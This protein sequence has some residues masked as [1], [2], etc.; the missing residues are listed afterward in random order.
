ML[1]VAPSELQ[2]GTLAVN[3]TPAYCRFRV[4]NADTH[5]SLSVKL[6]AATYSSCVRFQLCDD[7]LL[8]DDDDADGGVMYGSWQCSDT[9]GPTPKFYN[10][11]YDSI[12]LIELLEL[13]PNEAREIIAIFSP[14]PEVFPNVVERTAP[15]L[16]SGTIQLTST[17]L[18]R[19]T[20]ARSLTWSDDVGCVTSSCAPSPLLCAG[21]KGCSLLFSSQPTPLSRTADG[22][23]KSKTVTSANRGFLH[24]AVRSE[25][26]TLPFSATVFLSAFTVSVSELQATMA[27]SRTHLMGFKITNISPLP[28]QLVIRMQ[29]MPHKNVELTVCEEDQFEVSLIGRVLV[30]DGHAS[31]NFTVIVRTAAVSELAGSG[32]IMKRFCHRTVLQCDNLRDARNSELIS[33]NVNV[34]P[35]HLQKPLVSVADPYLD[36]GAVYRGTRVVREVSICNVSRED[37]TVRLLNPRPPHCEG[38]LTLVRGARSEASGGKDIK[39]VKNSTPV[40][41]TDKKKS[42]TAVV[43]PYD[44]IVPADELVMAAQKGSL[45]VGVMYVA[46]TDS[47]YKGTANLKFELDFVITGYESGA[48]SSRREQRVVVRCVATLFTSTIVAPLTNINFGDCPV[49]Q[50]RRVT[51][52]IENPS[53]LPT[54]I[55]V[56]LRSKIVSIEGVPARLSETGAPETVGEFSIAPQSSLPLTLRMTPQRVNPT[57]CKQLTVVNVSNPAEDRLILTIEANNMQPADMELHNEFYTCESRPLCYEDGVNKTRDGASGGSSIEADERSGG[58]AAPLRAIASVPLFVAYRLLSRVNYPLELQL[59]TTGAEIGTF[60]LEGMPS[61]DWEALAVELHSCCC[62]GGEDTA[63]KLAPERAEE[64]RDGVMRALNNHAMSVSSVVLEPRGSTTL[65]ACILRNS[66]GGVDAVTKEDGINIG[67]E[68]VELRRFMRLSYRVCSTRFELGGQRAKHFG[69]VNVGERRST[70]VPIT[71]QCNSLLLL[72]VTK[73]RSVMAGYIR[74]DGSDRN[75]IYFRIRPFATKELEL[76]FSPGLKGSLEERIQFVNILNPGNEVVITVKATVTKAETFD[77]SPDS[78]SFGLVSVPMLQPVTSGVATNVRGS[79]LVAGKGNGGAGNDDSSRQVARVGARFTVSNTSSAR[80]ALRLKLDTTV[81]NSSVGGGNE[82][83]H[84]PLERFF[85]FEGID[86]RLQ[87]EMERG[88]ASSGS[89]RKL[90]E[91]IEKLEQKLKIYRRKNK[92]DKVAAAVR[93][94]E[95]LKRALMG[96]VVDINTLEPDDGD[97]KSK[98]PQQQRLQDLKSPRETPEGE[99][100]KFAA[101]KVRLQ[102]HGELLSMLLRDG[103]ALSEMNAGESIILVLGITC[104]RTAEHIP[105][106]QSG[107]L[108]FVLYE[109]NDTEAS[110]TIPVDIT[111]V[112]V[113][114]EADIGTVVGGERPLAHAGKAGGGS[115]TDANLPGILPPTPRSPSRPGSDNPSP[116]QAPPE[117]SGGAAQLTRPGP[118]SQRDSTSFISLELGD[119]VGVSSF[120]CFPMISLNNCVVQERCDF[121]FYVRTTMDTSIVVLEPFRCCGPGV[122]TSGS[123]GGCMDAMVDACGAMD[124]REICKGSA[125]VSHMATARVVGEEMSALSGPCS[126][127]RATVRT[128]DASFRFSRRRGALHSRQ[129]LSINVQCTPSSSGPQRYFIPV[130]NLQDEGNV[131]YLVVSLNPS[132]VDDGCLLK[133]APSTLSM[134]DIVLPCDTALLDVQSFAVRSHVGRPHALLIRST[135]PALV[136]LFE[137]AKCS[138]PLKNPVRCSFSEK[139]KVYVQLRPSEHSRKHASR[140]VTAGILIEAIVSTRG[141]DCGHS[142]DP[143]HGGQCG[144]AILAHS[145]VRVSARIGSGEL[146]LR[147]SFIDMGSVAPHCHQAQ[148]TLTVWNPSDCF[149]VRAR[150]VASMPLTGIGIPEIT[151]PPGG[152]VDVPITLHIPTPGLVRESISLHNLS[153]KQKT[154]SVR[155]N[156]LRLDEAISVN[157]VPYEVQMQ[158]E[159]LLHSTAVHP[160]C[161]QD[162]CGVVAFPTAAVVCGEGGVFRLHNPVVSTAMHVTNNSMRSLIL[163]ARS[164][165]PFVFGHP[166][167]TLQ[168]SGVPPY[169]ED[170]FV[171]MYLPS[172][173][174]SYPSSLAETETETEA[175]AEMK[176]LSHSYTRGRLLLDARH[177]QA[178][179]WTLTSTPPFTL[180]QKQRLLRHELVTV[181][182]AAYIYVGQV[183]E[184]TT[185]FPFN[186]MMFSAV[187]P[188][189]MAEQ[190]VLVPKF[191]LNFAVSEG[192]AEPSVIDLGVV[193]VNKGHVGSSPLT[194]STAEVPA[195]QTDVLCK[196]EVDVPKL[197]RQ[198]EISTATAPRAERKDG[199][200]LNHAISI[201]L[202]NSSFVLPLNL[203]VECEPTVRFASNRVTVPPGQTVVVEAVLVPKLIQSEGPFRLS[204]YF[205]NE[206]NPEND[207]VVCVTGQYYQ[208]SFRLSW[209]GVVDGRKESLSM[210]PLRLEDISTATSAVLSQTKITMTAVEPNIEVGVRAVVNPELEGVIQLQALQYDASSTLQSVIFGQ[211]PLLAMAGNTNPNSDSVA[212]VSV[213]S[214]GAPGNGGSNNGSGLTAGAVGTGS[215]TGGITP[216]GADSGGALPAVGV[217]GSAGGPLNAGCGCAADNPAAPSVPGRGVVVCSKD[218]QQFRLRCV[219]VK[220]DFPVLAGVFF[221]Q[222]KHKHTADILRE[223]QGLT[224]TKLEELK[225][226][227]S[228]VSQTMW[229]GTLHFSNEVTGGDEEVQIFSSLSAFCTFKV[230]SKLVLRP[231]CSLTSGSAVDGATA[232][233]HVGTA[234]VAPEAM[235]VYEGELVVSNLCQEHVVRLSITPLLNCGHHDGVVLQ[236][237]SCDEGS[238]DTAGMSAD[239]A[240][241]T[242]NSN[243]FASSDIGYGDGANLADVC[244]KNDSRA[245]LPVSSSAHLPELPQTNVKSP[246]TASQSTV[247]MP[248]SPQ[249]TVRVRVLLCIDRARNK[250]SVEQGAGL[251]LFDEAVACSFAA[252]RISLA[253]ADD[254]DREKEQQQKQQEQL[255]RQ[256]FRRADSSGVLASGNSG[257]VSYKAVKDNI[258][259]GEKGV[260]ADREDTAVGNAAPPGSNPL[261]VTPDVKPDRPEILSSQLTRSHTVLSLSGNCTEV[262]DCTG[263]YTSSF[264]FSKDSVPTTDI[265]IT[266]HLSDGAVEYAVAVISQGP[267][268]WLLLPVSTAVLEPGETQP[269]RLNILST[270]A[271]SFVG[272]VSISSGITPGKLILL[273]LNAEVFLPTAGEGLFEILTSNG[274]RLSSGMEK[275]IFVGRLFG[276]KTH[277]ARVALEIVNRSSVPLEFPVSVGKSMRMEYIS[278]PGEEVSSAIM[279]NNI[280]DT[281]GGRDVD[282]K[283]GPRTAKEADEED[284]KQQEQRGAYNDGD[285][286]S[287][288]VPGASH[289]RCSVR[290]LVCHLHSVSAMR[291]ERYFVVDP[292][293]RLKVAFLLVCD[294]LQLPGGLSASGEAEVVLTCKQA[295]DARYVFKTYFRVCRPSFSVQREQ[296]FTQ[297]ENYTVALAVT[298]LNP[299]E[300]LILFRTASPVLVVQVPTEQ[301]GEDPGCALITIAGGAT[302]FFNVRLD[303]S[304]L[305]SLYNWSKSGNNSGNGDDTANCDV[306]TLLQPLSEHGVLLNVRNPSEHVRVE[307]CFFPSTTVQGPSASSLSAAAV[308]AVYPVSQSIKLSRRLNCEKRLYRFVQEFSRVLS[309]VS[310]FL[311]P[312]I[313]EHASLEGFLLSPT[314]N[315]GTSGGTTTGRG[316]GFGNNWNNGDS[317]HGGAVGSGGST[318]GAASHESVS[319]A[320]HPG[321]KDSLEGR[322]EGDEDNRVSLLEDRMP[323][324]Q[325]SHCWRALH[326]LLVDLSWLVEELVYYSIMLSNSR[327]I[328]AYGVFLATSVSGH[329]LLRLW[330]QHRKKLPPALPLAIFEQ[331]LEAIDALPC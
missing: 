318:A 317:T 115:S 124:D 247:I 285:R 145:V 119:V 189:P 290:L 143:I 252:V 261:D 283:T 101:S 311:L 102:E 40:K 8:V 220:E 46:S 271:G 55:N 42:S 29:T 104:T 70:K 248:I 95:E 266:N 188:L 98:D 45:Q 301:E 216:V 169:H 244:T 114:G 14:D 217:A 264:S 78:W 305:A 260:A 246:G 112:R 19:A 268:P 127:L 258:S 144:Y 254:N 64:V 71:N 326:G 13:H 300:S 21:D 282:L 110:R 174:D 18:P 280:S 31:M 272:H 309:E 228:A 291:G 253:P 158:G 58:G 236:C 68:H 120:M 53:L 163:I 134:R 219:L 1:K 296:L 116:M 92:V 201:R 99:D 25:T 207:M 278:A 262:R 49:G 226:Q 148:T 20:P 213:N 242:G 84:C 212:G 162:G 175:E 7:A 59:S 329:P 43:G 131:T 190:C 193:V 122:V 187:R 157:V 304:R 200:N 218:H 11:A 210:Q 222:R 167:T 75:S 255:T 269:L 80:R 308:A 315:D 322:E 105:A 117:T 60:C 48:N 273:K 27:P 82:N 324:S 100:E 173:P 203:S 2:F 146:V 138:V 185:G 90:E 32:A 152:K 155:L 151:L 176:P 279:R 171:S 286:G 314:V 156:V 321:R 89:S 181:E 302:A 160:G 310:E 41:I 180:K 4:Q 28:L 208:K 250:S 108:T 245:S 277:R 204:V 67:I 63:S 227:R 6:T 130:A 191:L 259:E 241:A 234:T 183:V 316:S 153:C 292:K 223:R 150:L 251:A 256:P 299:Q 97:T 111:L 192:R 38:V 197:R 149:E 73:S 141:L 107:I 79:T 37:L 295:R 87:L 12:N 76:T 177:T 233:A 265:T 229:L 294:H 327:A 136:R 26:L 184:E 270:D 39:S 323:S 33:V 94:I 44:N 96:E 129:P 61:A 330:R 139:L 103:I 293:S 154:L 77:V 303:I 202:V 159:A 221:G 331:F 276:D 209:D 243:N 306:D 186:D 225:S 230:S 65:Y 298:N 198:A 172:P 179:A 240:S 164:S 91:K 224:F 166:D 128:L 121:T 22:T 50:T 257:S 93:Q 57:Y 47:E 69:E 23:L 35:E 147:E 275:D 142:G 36:F 170:G 287:G 288:N 215:N 118:A 86:V 297:V 238:K 52:H 206:Q 199:N 106:A 85:R 34:V 137:D 168:L 182:V 72:R 16:V 328:E 10:A 81:S 231:R 237:V 313:Q 307:F 263:V 51:F 125:A 214:G 232:V 325:R 281:A 289:P 165:A 211:V 5:E 284:S 133:V 249:N 54:T 312:E 74:V 319:G 161:A 113:E 15:T 24:A 267:Q 178:V 83:A 196:N 123:Y 62:F 132:P 205:V 66:I 126:T 30:L 235:Y 109:A 9:L 274:Q 239:D 140:V 17:S 56:Q 3:E 195:K 194:S 320:G 135:R 88:G